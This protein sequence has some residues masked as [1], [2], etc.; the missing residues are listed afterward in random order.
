[1]S[2]QSNRGKVHSLTILL[3]VVAKLTNVDSA[4]ASARDESAAVRREDHMS[5]PANIMSIALRRRQCRRTRSIAPIPQ[6]HCS[7]GGG[8]CDVLSVG[9]AL[10]HVHPA[11]I[12]IYRKDT[13]LIKRVMDLE[14]ADG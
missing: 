12:V 5:T 7:I 8:G 1:M 11:P 2:V 13:L 14:G 3:D 9:R 6:P 4:A 10:R